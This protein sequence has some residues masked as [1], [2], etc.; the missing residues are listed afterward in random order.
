MNSVG[1]RPLFVMGCPRSGTTLMRELLNNHP[2]IALPNS[3]FQILP[4]VL[5][6]YGFN[7]ML[8]KEDLT[9]YVKI[10]S[11]SAFYQN[12]SDNKNVAGLRSILRPGISIEEAILETFLYFCP[13]PPSGNVC[14]AGDKTPDSL[15]IHRDIIKRFS[16]AKIIVMLRDPRDV[17]V[18]MSAAWS[19]SYQRGAKK[20][21]ECWWELSQLQSGWASQVHVVRYESLIE[22]PG[23]ELKKACD[24]LELSYIE[25]M[26]QSLT[27]RERMGRAAGAKSIVSGNS[28][29]YREVLSTAELS[30]I[31]SFLQRELDASGYASV[32]EKDRASITY[33]MNRIYFIRDSIL[34][35]KRPIQERGLLSGVNYRLK[36]ILAR[37]LG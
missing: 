17:L 26:S 20:W 5:K 12:E 19:K 24:F 16:D 15:F 6:R 35:F 25:D 28:G 33:R 8:S 22:N 1:V 32:A 18:S 30:A 29:K 2:S 36:Q 37:C 3:E 4:R 11:K 34:A 21:K 10:I 27:G 23:L 14:Y 9:D 7:A 31:E 13:A